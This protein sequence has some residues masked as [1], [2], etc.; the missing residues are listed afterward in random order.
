MYQSLYN[1]IASGVFDNTMTP[2]QI[3][4]VEM[5]ATFLS[6]AFVLLPIIALLGVMKS[7]FDWR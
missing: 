6:S 2:Y 3:E 5:V 4:L 1:L 7:F